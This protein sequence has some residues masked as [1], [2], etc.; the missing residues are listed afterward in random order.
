MSEGIVKWFNEKKDT[1]LSNRMTDKICLFI[2]LTLICPAS[3]PYPK[4]TG[5][6]LT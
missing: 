3:K 6:V 4:V 1:A 5:Y 2:I